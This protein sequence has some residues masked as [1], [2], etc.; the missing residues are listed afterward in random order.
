MNFLYDIQI[1]YPY[2]GFCVCES[3]VHWAALIQIPYPFPMAT[4]KREVEIS[5]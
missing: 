2:A 4:Q 5:T 3:F 1:P